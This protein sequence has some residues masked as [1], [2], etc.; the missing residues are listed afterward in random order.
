[1]KFAVTISRWRSLG[2]AGAAVLA[3][4]L[5]ACGSGDDS[6]STQSGSAAT[7]TE[8]SA[9]TMGRFVVPTTILAGDG[10]GSFKDLP[11]KEADVETGPS[12]LPLLSKGTLAG[13]SDVSESPIA[14][15]YASNIPVK[16]VWTSNQTPLTLVAKPDITSAQ[17]LRGKKVAAAGGSV[18]QYFLERYLAENGMKLS[19]VKFVDLAP[20]DMVGAFS[21]GAIDA[22]FAWPPF[23][24][25]M[26]AKGGKALSTGR[27]TNMTIFSQKF[28]DEHPESVQAFVCD[29][30]RLHEVFAKDP[31]KAYAALGKR[32]NLDA[33]AVRPLLPVETVVQPQQMI[34][35][36]TL[37]PGGRIARQIKD[38][39]DWLVKNGQVPKAP[40]L[41]EVNAMIDTRFVQAVNE[42]KC[43]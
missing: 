36:E 21:T 1:M 35:E 14:I 34:T 32:L 12:A 16:L 28:V 5:A 13:I 33:D 38:V 23:S 7:T 3:L 37:A 2:V 9:F 10:L 39:S 24:T 11:M 19:D 15:A 26:E 22:A 25:A 31:A 4:G 17:D 42:G 41:D 29:M 43:P 30:A 6:G 8:P 27:S 40:S 18:L 20:P